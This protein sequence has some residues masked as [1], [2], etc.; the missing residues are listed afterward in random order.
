MQFFTGSALAFA[1]HVIL[2]LLG[3]FDKFA[4]GTKMQ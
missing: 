2:F 4:L 3:D 1:V